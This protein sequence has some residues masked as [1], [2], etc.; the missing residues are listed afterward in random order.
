MPSLP[1]PYHDINLVDRSSDLTA[2]P[3]HKSSSLAVEAACSA[4]G[5]R[6]HAENPNGFVDR[7]PGEIGIFR[8][9]R[10]PGVA[11]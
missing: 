1:P 3:K 6:N 11:R 5:R 10:W 9:G 8:A 7:A 4:F 2:A